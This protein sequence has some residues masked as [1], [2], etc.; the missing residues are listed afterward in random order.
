MGK[1]ISKCKMCG[2]EFDS[3]D[4]NAK[5][6]NKQCYFLYRKEN[7]KLKNAICPICNKIFRQSRVEQMFCGVEC[8]V[9][10][11][12]DRLKCT[13]EHCGKDFV[14]I[15]SEVEKNKHHY[16][17]NKCRMDAMYWCPDDVEILKSNFGKIKYKSMTNI[18]S[19][20]RSQE[21]IK[22]KAVNLGLTSSRKWSDEEIQILI[23]NYSIKP[24]DEVVKMLPS[25][26]ISA[27]LGQARQQNLKS[28]FYLDHM[29]SDEEEQYLKNNYL[30]KS[31]EELGNSLNRTP[32]AIAQHL[33]VLDLHRPIDVNNHNTIAE[34]IRK[35]IYPWRKQY[36]KSKN[37]SC[38]L[39]GTTNSIVVHH[40]RG[41]NLLLEETIC[42]LNFPIY[43]RMSLYT[44]EQLDN[45]VKTFLL[46]QETYHNYIC[47]NENIHKQ[48]HGIYGYG[49]NTE[50]Q[51]NDFIKKYYK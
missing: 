22:R 17:S 39:T 10:S 5:F 51:W 6:C 36:V 15:R 8:R 2:K 26:T 11:T 27:I 16:C 33:L 20:Y 48:F 25:R 37:Y 30:T 21:E 46:V 43:E 45:L 13:C 18:F 9:K 42:V 19:K 29:Y 35:R 31:N 32:I 14:R 34:Y 47:I 4:K 49:S 28:F 24:M 23:D 41:F 7:G 38:E 1:Y 3:Y 44:K 12:E 50:W 40:I